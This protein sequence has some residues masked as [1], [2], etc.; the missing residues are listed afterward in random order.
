MTL[1]RVVVGSGV[2]A[3]PRDGDCAGFFSTLVRQLEVLEQGDAARA[4]FY[5]SRRQYFA[6]HGGRSEDALRSRRAGDD[7]PA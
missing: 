1:R 2:L 5:A 7:P 4:S 6:G 3:G